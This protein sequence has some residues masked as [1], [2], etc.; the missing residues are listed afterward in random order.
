[1]V[2]Q[3]CGTAGNGKSKFKRRS[4]SRCP[5]SPMRRQPNSPPSEGNEHDAGKH[6]SSNR[7][8]TIMKSQHPPDSARDVVVV[9]ATD[10]GYAMPLAV[11]IRS[12]LDHLDPHR[13]LRLY[14]LDGGLSDE[15]KTRLFKSWNDPRLTVHW[16]QP[17]MEQVRDLF[18]SDQV[19]VVTY[20]R[21]LMAQLLPEQVTRAIY[22]DAD[23]LVR[24]D[25]GQL[26]DE[27]QGDHAVL[28]VPDIAAP[29]LDAPAMLPN[30]KNC[31]EHLCAWTPIVNFRELG[32]PADGQ[33]FNG[34]LLVAD[35]TRWRRENFAEQML[36]CLREHREH[37]L[38]WDQYA[39]NVVLARKWR[40][41]NVRWNQNAHVFV[42][43]SWQKSPLDRPTFTELRE[44]PWIVH[45]CSPSKPWRY[46]CR[47]PFTRDFRRCLKRTDWKGWQ[48]ARPERFLKQWWE[49]HYLPLRS[50]WKTNV[51]AI[52]QA[53]R[54]KRA[55]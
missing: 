35:L 17:N 9:S 10:N 1:M 43:P 24:Q 37:V 4:K 5:L 47:H 49:Y 51:R 54:R 53:I 44:S 38:W 41:L 29:Y 25:L 45:F 14:V 12:A 46:F 21:L 36:R 28:A 19:T 23:M 13:R 31:C 3:I 22:I 40:P 52:K 26:W 6:G 11:T 42:Y 48:P 18:V 50:E 7:W 55:A 30:F 27:P 39:L 16:V 33:Y 8:E 32:L 34:G 15:S 2:P 20:L